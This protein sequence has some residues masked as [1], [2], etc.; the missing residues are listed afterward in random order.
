MQDK[1]LDSDHRDEMRPISA[2]RCTRLYRVRK[3]IST[4]RKIEF[5]L[6]SINSKR[7]NSTRDCIYG[8]SKAAATTLDRNFG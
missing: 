3:K 1:L 5:L 8:R 4:H 6:V 2:I 7:T